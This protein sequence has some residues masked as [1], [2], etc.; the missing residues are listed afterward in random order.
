MS[1]KKNK[2]KTLLD[3]LLYYF[4]IFILGAL[5]GYIYEV[6][7]YYITLGVLNNWGILYG[8]WLPIYGVGAVFLSMLKPLKKNPILLFILSII[9]TGLLEYIVGYISVNIFNQRLW[10]YTGLFLNINGLVCLRSVLTFAVGSLIL[11]YL[12][13]PLIDKYYNKMIKCK[14]AKKKKKY[15][16]AMMSYFRDNETLGNFQKVKEDYQ[17][18]YKTRK[19]KIDNL[20]NEVNIIK[21]LKV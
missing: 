9:I 17:T 10:D 1:K 14:D 18:A 7:F 19:E 21:K 5:T 20:Y 2:K 11:N 3:K 12:L 15:E 13:L 4:V 16:Q 8:P 6:I